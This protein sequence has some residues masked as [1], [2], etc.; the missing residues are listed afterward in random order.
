M[1]DLC[2]RNA[3]LR[4]KGDELFDIA[5][6]D[7]RIADIGKRLGVL[8]R[9]EI[10]AEGSLVTESFA[11]PHLHLCKVWT[12]PMMNE[13]ALAAYHG[14]DMGKALAAI[15]LASLVK[16]NYDDSWIVR[17]ARRAVALA[18][19]HGNLHIR[20]FA[21]VDSK[22]RLEGVKALIAVREEFR[23]VVDIQVVAFPQDGIMRE[24][25]AAALL[26]QAM[27]LGADVI[28]GIPWIELTEA[29]VIDHI[30]ICFDYSQEF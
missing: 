13:A 19:L 28:G 16:A 25:G 29:D 9:D 27:E 21:D 23:G 11:N 3:R 24:P 26:H 12:L 8:A 4:Q 2:I 15:D 18:A 14:A 17:N 5:I 20:A 6:A 30:N 10:D 7:G 22:A 1:V